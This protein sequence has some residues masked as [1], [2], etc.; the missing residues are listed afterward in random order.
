M[1]FLIEVS[2]K[3]P[4][5]WWIQMCWTKRIGE[6][7][8]K[9]GYTLGCSTT[10]NSHHQDSLWHLFHLP[11][12]RHLHIPWLHPGASWQHSNIYPKNHRTSRPALALGSPVFPQKPGWNFLF[13]LEGPGTDWYEPIEPLGF[14]RSFQIKLLTLDPWVW[15]WILWTKK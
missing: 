11:L 13:F 7:K 15:S 4:Q 1:F 8:V 14:F 3:L 6:Y 2:L 5:T 9:G 12:S 10:G